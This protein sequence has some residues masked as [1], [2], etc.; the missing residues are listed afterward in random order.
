MTQAN[1]SN[2]KC[3]ATNWQIMSV[4]FIP[5]IAGQFFFHSCLYFKL[6]YYQELNCPPYSCRF[7]YS[8]YRETFLC[9][10]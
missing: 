8:G 7:F 9:I 1:F 3:D 6:H 10:Q 5:V 4:S 2:S